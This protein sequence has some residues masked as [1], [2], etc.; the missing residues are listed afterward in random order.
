MKL[1]GYD[2]DL[3]AY[4][5][6]AFKEKYELLDNLSWTISEYAAKRK[7]F[8]VTW[9]HDESIESVIGIPPEQVRKSFGN[10]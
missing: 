8:F 4:S 5:G 1:E 6:D 9:N 7:V 10:S 2:V 3:R